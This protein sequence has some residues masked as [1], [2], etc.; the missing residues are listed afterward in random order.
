MEYQLR[1]T[2]PSWEDCSAQFSHH[3]DQRQTTRCQNG[4]RNE[5]VS[6]DSSSDSQATNASTSDHRTD[7]GS[8]RT[9]TD[10]GSQRKGPSKRKAL[11]SGSSFVCCSHGAHRQEI[12]SHRC[13]KSTISPSL[14]ASI[15]GCPVYANG[16]GIRRGFAAKNYAKDSA[17]CFR[18]KISSRTPIPQSPTEA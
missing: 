16:L 11:F 8:D 3:P 9:S 4:N 6:E 17:P 15:P 18:R 2:T 5:T 12:G 1:R 7:S 10:L 13:T 14:L